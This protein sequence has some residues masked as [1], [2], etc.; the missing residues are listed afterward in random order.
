MAVVHVAWQ[1]CSGDVLLGLSVPVG[2]WSGPDDNGEMN[3]CQ[4]CYRGCRGPVGL[5][6]WLLFC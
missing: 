3:I 6:V 2:C 5:D 1:V 4:R